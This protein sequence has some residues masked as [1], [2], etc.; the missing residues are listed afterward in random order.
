MPTGTD[1]MFFIPVSAVPKHKKATYLRVV[2][3]ERPEKPNPRRVR[4]TVG[5]DRIDYPGDVSTKTADLTTV[6][7]LLNSV[8][9]TPNAKFMTMDIK[10]FYLNT[11]LDEY[12]YMRIPVAFIPTEIFEFYNLKDLVHNGFVYVE[13][14]KGMYGLPQAG[15]IAN[16]LLTARLLKHG[17]TPVPIT[18]GLWVHKTRGTAFSLVVDDFGVLYVTDDDANHLLNALKENYTVSVDWEGKRYCG[19]TLEWD[20]TARTCDISMPGYIERALQRFKHSPPPRPQHSPH[21]WQ[22]PDYGAKTQYAPAPDS[23][24]ALDCADTKRVQEVL[25][26]LLFY[27]RAVDSTMLAAIGTLASQQASG[28]QHTMRGITHLLNYCASH[29]DA[30]VRFVASDMILHVESDASY[31]SEPKARSR[32]AGYYYLSNMPTTPPSATTPQP[33]AN[34][35]INILCQILREV[36]SS[37]AEAELA[38][39]FHLHGEYQY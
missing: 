1:T 27:A 29:P 6:K 2:V 38:A 7:L 14:R 19:L 11:P 20:Y 13:I 26:T 9:S 30:V 4:F 18:P 8:L 17:Y 35:A 33:T 16:D 10:D 22:R 28:T 5:G 37:A 39:L 36:V 23:S 21:E 34:G 12:E 15:R 3:A 25:G 24:P 31:L 32:A